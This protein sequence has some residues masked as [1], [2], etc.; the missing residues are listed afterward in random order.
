MSSRRSLSLESVSS[1][2]SIDT[3]QSFDSAD[4]APFMACGK[5]SDEHRAEGDHG[6]LANDGS[7]PTYE[8]EIAAGMATAPADEDSPSF[9]LDPRT[10]EFVLDDGSLYRVFRYFFEL[11]SP[12]FVAQYLSKDSSEPVQLSGVSGVDFDRFLSLMYP[13]ELAGCDVKTPSE[14]ISVLRL[15]IKWSFPA[16]RARAIKE[17]ERIGSVIDKICAARE[18]GDV[19]HGGMQPP[20]DDL[21][22]L[23]QW[24]LPAFTE[25]CTTPK[26]LA[27]VS[28][29]DAERLGAGTILQV[30]RIREELR[31]AG[32]GKFDVAAAIVEAGLAPRKTTKISTSPKSST[33][34]PHPTTSPSRVMFAPLSGTVKPAASAVRACSDVAEAER[35]F[36]EMVTARPHTPTSASPPTDNITGAN[37]KP[38]PAAVPPV[39]ASPIPVVSSVIPQSSRASDGATAEPSTITVSRTK[40]IDTLLALEAYGMAD[41]GLAPTSDPSTNP[42][43]PS[44]PMT[45]APAA[46]PSA[47]LPSGPVAIPVEPSGNPTASRAYV[48]ELLTGEK[49]LSKNQRKKMLRAAR[50]SEADRQ[51]KYQR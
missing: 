46:L 42:H 33:S 45:G 9:L 23:Q 2:Q 28:L 14:W 16:L 8:P 47:A 10:V 18:F 48:H 26:W 38:A 6:T 49:P 12:K 27:S 7:L 15:A 19:K 24:L 20:D 3:V 30:G 13:S 35:A 50:A 11:H 22:A 41:A 29:D 40:W 36:Q 32:A 21:K 31:D 43:K 5:A 4:G 39:I 25:A 17:I 34:K 1:M 51:A 37:D 44:V